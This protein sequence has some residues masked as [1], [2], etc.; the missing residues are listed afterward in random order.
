M[1]YL[2]AS[3]QFVA[4][5]HLLPRSPL[6]GH[7]QQPTEYSALFAQA[8]YNCNQVCASVR[9]RAQ[10]PASSRRLSVAKPMLSSLSSLP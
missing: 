6:R 9:H 1:R 8:L 5:Q 3:D 10:R 2:L 7:S 4:V